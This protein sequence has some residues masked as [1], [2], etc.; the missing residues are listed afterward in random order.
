M[1][2]TYEPIAT[3]TLGSN[4]T[5]IEFPTIP[6]TYTDLFISAKFKNT[7][8]VDMFLRFNNDTNTNYSNTYLYGNGSTGLTSRYTNASGIILDMGGGGFGT[9]WGTYNINIMNYSN[10]TSHK[11]IIGRS[12]FYPVHAGMLAGLWRSTSAISSIKISA[13]S[14]NAIVSGSTFTLFGIKAA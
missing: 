14:A 5:E 11:T 13:S 7:T 9:D 1:A 12:G 4:N 10:S 3:T 2:V 8:S 6:S